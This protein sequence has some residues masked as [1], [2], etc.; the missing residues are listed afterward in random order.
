[1]RTTFDGGRR[2]A[3][4][5]FGRGRALLRLGVKPLR[6]A[7]DI[8]PWRERSDTPS[9]TVRG[10]LGSVPTG[11]VSPDV[12][13]ELRDREVSVRPLLPLW[14]AVDAKGLSHERLLV[15]CDSTDAQMT[16]PRERVS[17]HSFVRFL[18]N[19][20][21]HFDDDQLV[22]LGEAAVSSPTLRALLL[23][24][25]LLYQPTEFYLWVFGTRG[26]ATQMFVTQQGSIEQLGPGHLRFETHMKPGYAAS[27]ENFLLMQGSLAGL[28]R[29]LGAGLAD[30]TYESLPDGARYDIKLTHDGGAL[31]FLRR[32]V[33]APVAAFLA[34][35]ELR[36]AND[37][38]FERYV[39][40]RQS[41]DR[42]E[43][44]AETT[45][46]EL[47]RHSSYDNLTGL[48]KRDLFH[49]QVTAALDASAE[50][51]VGSSVEPSSTTAVLILDLDRFKVVNDSLG[52]TAGDELLRMASD[53]LCEIVGA[54]EVV[55]RFGGD[56]FAV[57]LD[58]IDRAGVAAVA[59]QLISAFRQP[60]LIHGH[61]VHNSVSIGIAFASPTERDTAEDLFRHADAALYIAKE[62]GRDRYEVF[63]DHLRPRLLDR[64][65]NE[66]DLR[67][68]VE[69][70]Q[71]VLHYQPVFHVEG[72]R[73]AGVEALVRWN[74]PTRGLLAAGEFVPFAE[75]TGL[76]VPLGE[77]VLGEACRQQ[78]RWVQEGLFMAVN[79]S[80]NQ[81]NQADAMQRVLA[82][83]E[84]ADVDPSTICLEITETSLMDD[85]DASL[86][87]LESLKDLGVELAIDDFGTGYS[88]L[89][90]LQRFPIDSL[91]IDKTFVDGL[92]AESHDTQIVEAIVSLADALDLTTI[93]EGVETEEQLQFLMELGCHYAQGY[94]L[95]RP[96]PAEDICAWR[97]QTG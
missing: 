87:R 94:L 66:T 62:H 11:T 21:E 84:G 95:G 58:G 16:N 93:A 54:V 68:A 88:S 61:A 29:T 70:S 20:A 31:R 18:S 67:R 32:G 82:I 14:A 7:A 35:R 75:E 8:V 65:R 77:W 19:L 74:H 27:R 47:V 63:D 4:V 86:K 83:L 23:P 15:G 45:E 92:G 71:F 52:H 59:E 91:K 57:L 22:A 36:H 3:G 96:M 5:V 46:A 51:S 17:W 28:S 53:R 60:F 78:A 25:R 97:S 69:L 48:A 73:M 2:S 6:S 24:G 13:A 50:S 89:A 26:P 40:L 37:E 10:S 90:Y 39:E 43:R 33:A 85:V 12:P 64:L 38:L 30:V 49:E 79:L 1:M 76:I 34:A 42:F 41:E 44:L 56:E 72:R 81:L 9:D 55:A 80:A